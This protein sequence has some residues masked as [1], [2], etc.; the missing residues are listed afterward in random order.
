MPYIFVIICG[1]RAWLTQVI[2]SVSGG[3]SLGIRATRS[4]SA[5]DQDRIREPKPGRQ[6]IA[7]RFYFEKA[8]RTVAAKENPSYLLHVP[9]LVL[10]AG[11][12]G[13]QELVEVPNL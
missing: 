10:T 4:R 3:V 13:N 1:A 12:A 5:L 9:R 2:R 6:L 11:Q 8:V 7:K